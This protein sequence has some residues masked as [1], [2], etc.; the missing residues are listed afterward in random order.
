METQYQPRWNNDTAVRATA[1]Q[2]RTAERPFTGF[3]VQTHL[4]AGNCF[5]NFWF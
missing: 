1:S 3:R 5:E 2:R 4:R